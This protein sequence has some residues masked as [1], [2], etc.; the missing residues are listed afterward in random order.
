[1]NDY[2]KLNIEWCG[3]ILAQIGYG[4]QTRNI[5]RPLIEGGAKV[6]LI[7]A[8]E[9]VPEHRKVNEPFWIKA[10][11]ESKVMPDMPMRINFSIAPQFRVRPGAINVGF[12]QWET[13]RVPNEWVPILNQMDYLL[14]PSD[15]AIDAYRMAGVNVPIKVLRPNISD[16]G[17]DGPATSISEIPEGTVKFLFSS[18]WIPR[19]NHSDLITAFCCAFHGIQDAALII[20][21]WPT[22]DDTNNKRHIENGVRHFSD[23]LRGINRP[24]IY[25]LSDIVSQEKVDSIIRSCDVYVSASKAEGFD[26]ATI[27]AMAMQKLV[28]GI[29]L[30]IRSEYIKPTTSLPIDFSLEP[31]V[32]SAAPGYDTYQAW[33]R[34]NMQS[35]I[36][37]MHVAYNLIKNPTATVNDLTALTAKQ[38]GKNARDR[39]LELYSPEVNT[40]IIYNTLL[41]IQNEVA[42]KLTNKPPKP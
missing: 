18:N 34:P 13:T 5:L 20:K 40:P 14:V 32:D 1:M 15:T 7:P 26:S 28:L 35:L 25:L 33:A 39:V 22:N 37:A 6:K 30:G 12:M 41:E 10:L 36:G 29:P 4:V 9:Y 27:S 16:P 24:R 3:E 42:A 8:E 19:K 23:R 31:I 38:L 11:E 21:T 2:S 17:V